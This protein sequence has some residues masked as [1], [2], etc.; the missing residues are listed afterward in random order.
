MFF[1]VRTV[2][3]PLSI[4]PT[5]RQTVADLDNTI[6][7]M[8]I[9]TQTQLLKQSII[10]E[11]LFTT[12]CG[13]L[14]VLGILLSC[15][16]LYGLLSFMVTRRTNEIGVR[17]ALGA[18]PRDAAWPVMR[19]ALSLAAFGLL[20]GIP[21]A[22]GLNQALRRVLFGIKPHDPITIIASVFLLLIIAAIAAWIPARRAAKTDP[23]EALRYE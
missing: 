9:S 17:M 21:L 20:I 18:R 12:L 5:I 15:I 14:A 16:G 11:R 7:M 1:E 23:M 4:V 2:L 3:E 6:P 13:S 19:N 8:H 22:L 10:I